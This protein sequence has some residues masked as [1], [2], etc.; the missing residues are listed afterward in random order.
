MNSCEN[1]CTSGHTFKRKYMDCPKSFILTF[2]CGFCCE[3]DYKSGIGKEKWMENRKLVLGMPE[4]SDY[5]ISKEEMC[6]L[7]S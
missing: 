3:I 2:Y 6:P 4:N 7:L 1:I 5:T